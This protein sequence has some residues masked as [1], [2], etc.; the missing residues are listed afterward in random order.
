MRVRSCLEDRMTQTLRGCKVL[1]P[2]LHMHASMKINCM[3]FALMLAL[4]QSVSG[5]FGS[6]GL[7]HSLPTRT[8]G[9]ICSTKRIWS[10]ACLEMDHDLQT[11]LNVEGLGLCHGI[12]HASGLRR[13]SDMTMLTD[14]EI[15]SMGFDNIDK[16]NILR[17]IEKLESNPNM[18]VDMDVPEPSIQICTLIDGAFDRKPV[19]RFEEVPKQDFCIEVLSA[20]H[21]VYKGR[22]FTKD[23][24][25]Q[26]N[27]MSEHNHYKNIGTIGAG[28]TNEIFTLTAQHMEC[29]NMPGF[30]PRTKFIFEELLRRE[31]YT[32]FPGKLVDGSIRFESKSDPHLVKYQ[33]NSDSK[34]APSRGTVLHTD[35]PE[36]LSI[37]VNALLSPDDDFQGGGTYFPALGKTIML[38]Q[39]EMI[40]HLGDLEHAGVEIT[41]GV[42]RLLVAFIACEWK[43]K[44]LNIPRPD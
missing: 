23:Q 7:S 29:I 39:G 42:R 40:I 16:N 6:S 11:E 27:R 24:C 37:T 20:E 35:S 5:F 1:T 12:L 31:L 44:A 41:S 21:N 17:V 2:P 34:K 19:A 25:D 18:D 14:A 32:L 4:G 3:R 36:F 43:E 28:W 22:L 9:G 38:E 30:L 13:L 26:I 10:H 33:Y 8:R 15:T